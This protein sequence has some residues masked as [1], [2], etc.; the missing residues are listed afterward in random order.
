M[1]VPGPR[2]KS[3]PQLH[4]CQIPN[5]LCHAGIKP[6]TQQQQGHILNPLCQSR[7]SLRDLSCLLIDFSFFVFGD[8][9]FSSIS[10]RII[11][12]RFLEV[13]FCS[14]KVFI[15]C[16]PFFTLLFVLVVLEVFLNLLRRKTLNKW[17]VITDC[18]QSNGT[19]RGKS[20]FSIGTRVSVQV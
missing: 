4:Q 12:H 14:L 13:F 16:V 6:V 11:I 15:S 7:N 8:T 5:P 1:Q 17:P 20:S 3:K 9:T 19:Q 10:L 18:V 2:I